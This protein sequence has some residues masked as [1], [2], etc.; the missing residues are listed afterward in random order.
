MFES[1]DTIADDRPIITIGFLGAFKYGLTLGKLI[2][3]AIPLAIDRIN[4]DPN[5]LPNH[6]L[7][8]KAGDSGIPNG[9]TAIRKMTEMRE[10]NNVV[11]Y[12]GPDHSCA[13]EALV[14][15]AWNLPL[16]TYKCTDHKVSNKSIYPTFARTLPPSSK[17]SK[18][19]I[20]LLKHFSWNK[21]SL[22][23]SDTPPDRQVEESLISMCQTYGVII[24][25]KFYLP[26]EYLSKNNATIKTII[27]K[28]YKKTRVYV[29][30]S[31]TYA[32]VDFARV[33]QE[34]QL[35]D[36]GKYVI[37]S[38]EEEEV[39]DPN[40]T[41]QYISREFESH[42]EKLDPLPFR[43][44]YM[45][46]PTAPINQ[47]YSHFKTEVN[48]RNQRPPFNIPAH[49]FIT[50]QVPIY[51]GLAYDAVMIYAN[52]LTHVLSMG[53][54]VLN[55]TAI[56]E[57]IKRKS[58]KSILGFEVMMD[59]KGDAEGNYTLLALNSRYGERQ[60]MRPI[61]AFYY[62]NSD[63]PTLR[64]EDNI[65]WIG[66]GP[67]LAE[68]HCGFDD[69]YCKYKRDWKLIF[70]FSISALIIL[71]AA[72]F[73]FRHYR[74]EHKLTRLLWKID[75]KDVIVLN[76]NSEY[77]LQNIRNTINGIDM[78]RLS[79]Y[80]SSSSGRSDTFGHNNII[81]TC[82][83]SSFGIGVYK[84][85]VVAIKRIFKKSIDLTR[86]VRK[87]L[88][89]VRE[90]RHEN[91]N[92]FIGASIESTNISLLFLYC[93]RG[94]LEDV[95]KNEDLDLDNMFIAS[96]VAD[97]IK[98]MIYLHDSDIISHGRL[99]SSN[100]LVDSRWVLQITDYGLHEFRAN[101]D[102]A[103]FDENKRQRDLIWRAPELLRIINTPSRGTQ[104]GDVY[105]FAIILYE[106]IGRKGPIGGDVNL[107]VNE[108]LEQ[109]INPS[110]Y[111]RIYRPPVKDIKCAQYI[112]RCIEECWHENPDS[113]PDFRFINIRLREM[114]SGLKPNIFDNMITMLEKY[115]YNL[116]G[117]V[118]ERT[119][120]LMEEKKKTENLLLRMLPKSVAEQLKRCAAVEAEFFE[121]VT[122][123]FSDI[124]GFT[125]LSAISTPL[126]IIS[127]LND[128]Y[129]LFDEIIG[130]YD[131][132]KVETI[133]D[134]YMVVSGLP[135]RNNDKHAAEIASMALHLLSAIQN[136]E[137]KHRS[138]ERLKLRIG[139][140]SGP[141]VAG[142]VGLKMPRYCLF[143]DTVNTASRMESTGLA[144]RI[145]VS[146]A[147]KTILDKLGGY[148]IQER[149]IISIKGKGEM[150][151]FWLIGK[152]L[153][154]HSKQSYISDCNSSEMISDFKELPFDSMEVN[155]NANNRSK[156][157]NSLDGNNFL[158]NISQNDDNNS[159]TNTVIVN[160]N[161]K[162]KS[163]G[164]SNDEP[165][166]D[167]NQKELKINNI[168]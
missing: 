135:I 19:V 161:F 166:E 25:N 55:G 87:E 102:F 15:A 145:H 119:N 130:N 56:L 45:I 139:I 31:E 18:S 144:L 116:E 113:R 140:H 90:M 36:T 35:L 39:Y 150:K 16:I 74:Y 111:G 54:S 106:I 89:Q 114:Q 151:S 62:N 83:Q 138:C 124:V 153:V 82:N 157:T 141:C 52:A 125:Q 128:L 155:L 133:G 88:I 46:T 108:I 104:K 78:R 42:L 6:T 167:Q 40:K 9:W 51:A 120:Q 115:A 57:A 103:Y 13:T 1:N 149:G 26:G 99:K 37:I 76:T 47:N 132:Y 53:G 107:S 44:V 93:A 121:C 10:Q 58:Y 85:N 136:F 24:I 32:L 160:I 30:L 137:I 159:H 23:V 152:Q 164:V 71:I 168:N 95:L 118:Q 127:L 80:G 43:A 38:V 27:E 12:I 64:L 69:E 4:S 49:P 165:H 41:M 112:L 96:L 21:I 92:S 72:V 33:M 67:P 122:I 81:D 70:I 147:C 156:M 117:L 162:S 50:V 97:L 17:I 34:R 123:Y 109:I 20:S 79:H 158:A 8:F 75:M 59:E 98:G 86:N 100:C 61:G 129:T 11:A 126:Q 142:V 65:D 84:G 68:P 63:L 163:N 7:R 131:V 14:A 101:Q 148:V 154:N 110:H 29:L 105:S 91:I 143:G 94:S 60:G 146:E 134:A 28:S 3:G 22:V 48:Q 73:I 66:D 5:I 77:T 2:A